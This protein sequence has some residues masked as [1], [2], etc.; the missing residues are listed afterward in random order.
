MITVLSTNVSPRLTYICDFI[1]KEQLGLNYNITTSLNP[2]IPNN[3]NCVIG[4]GIAS[5]N[6]NKQF[7]IPN[8]GLLFQNDIRTQTISIQEKKCN[9]PL[10]A[11]MKYFFAGASPDFDFDLFAACFYLISRY[12]EYLC[13]HTDE[14][15]RFPHQESLA[16]QADFLHLPLVN[17]W[18]TEFVHQLKTVFPDLI[19]SRPKFNTQISYDVDMA[20][21]YKNKG[22]LRTLGGF[23]KQPSWNKIKVLHGKKTDPFNQ[24][25]FIKETHQNNLSDVIFFFLM[26]EKTSKYDKNSSPKNTDMQALIQRISANSTIGLHPSWQS[27]FFASLLESEKNTLDTISKKHIIHSR[28]HYL[29]FTLPD[30]YEQLIQLGI[31]NEY[32]MGYGSINGFRASFAGNFSWFNLKEN[33]ATSLRIHP[34]SF[35]DANVIFEEKL[36]IDEA[37][38]QLLHQ[39][40]WCK[41]TNGIFSTVFHN[42]LLAD[43]KDFSSWRNFYQFAI[44]Q[45]LQ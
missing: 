31:K 20:W 19:I 36:N 16:F 42:H 45:I 11:N 40:D 23:I 14:Y 17:I 13:S 35:M 39:L 41:K 3:H 26:A 21:S 34:F 6:P 9:A 33:A 25:D 38:I 1:F 30:T 7:L 28:Q 10:N 18:L 12:E 22:W 15:N 8:H 4:Y 29:K 2:Q 27:N 44:P 37:K 24:F 5:P 32:S 43:D